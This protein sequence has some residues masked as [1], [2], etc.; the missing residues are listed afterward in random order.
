[1]I[2][3]AAKTGGATQT[4]RA[5]RANHQERE[6]IIFCDSRYN[7]MYYICSRIV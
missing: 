5:F 6:N 3:R 2:H 1:M 7:K 4:K